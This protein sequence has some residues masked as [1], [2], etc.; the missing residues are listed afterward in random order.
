MIADKQAN[1][2]L[3]PG[4]LY[5]KDLPGSLRMQ[6]LKRAVIHDDHMDLLIQNIPDWWAGARVWS[7]DSTRKHSDAKTQYP[8]IYFF[9]YSNDFP[10]SPTNIR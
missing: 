4:W 2:K 1:S 10:D 7:I 5:P 3:Y 6:G 8:D 9:T